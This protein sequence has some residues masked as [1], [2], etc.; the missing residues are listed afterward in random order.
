[1]L[2]GTGGQHTAREVSRDAADDGGEHRHDG[3]D[4]DVRHRLLPPLE[5]VPGRYARSA[6]CERETI[7][8]RSTWPDRPMA[9][10]PTRSGECSVDRGAVRGAGPRARSR[11][12]AA[13]RGGAARARARSGDEPAHG[14]HVV[15]VPGQEVL[16]HDPLHPRRLEL[17]DALLEV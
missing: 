8:D 10:G 3:D 11:A 2:H 17:G 4:E 5:P 6:C 16:E 14:A 15:Q 13:P 7:R 1:M 12:A 9:S